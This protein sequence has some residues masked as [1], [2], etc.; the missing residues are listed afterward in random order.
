MVKCNPFA[1]AVGDEAPGSLGGCP[2][3]IFNGGRRAL[4]RGDHG[5]ATDKLARLKYKKDWL[6]FEDLLD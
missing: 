5:L 1:D 2:I 3:L 6:S 4:G